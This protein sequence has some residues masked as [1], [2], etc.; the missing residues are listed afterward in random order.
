M[1]LRYLQTFVSAAQTAS[2]SRTGAQL[3]LTQSAVSLQIRKLEEALGCTLFE[4]T[5]KAVRLSDAGRQRLPQALRVVEAFEALKRGEAD[6]EA[7]PALQIGAISTVQQGLLPLA[8]R[9][10]APRTGTLRLQVV[11]GTS[12]ELL[13]RI[14]AREIEA[15]LIVR[16]RLGLPDDLPWRPIMKDRFVAVAPSGSPQDLRTLLRSLP[17]LRYKRHS[18]GGQLVEQFLQRQ[19]LWV[20]DRLELDEPAAL[21][22]M[23]AEG[24]GCAILPGDLLPIRSTPGIQVLPLPARAPLREIGLLARAGALKLPAMKALLDGLRQAAAQIQQR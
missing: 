11:P 13:A 14:E 3:G 1:N 18:S 5:G 17:F 12:A 21:L 4:R 22:Q 20:N 7:P 24:L 6:A 8:L 10:A 23:V 16:P 19:R 9:L 15:A 2:F